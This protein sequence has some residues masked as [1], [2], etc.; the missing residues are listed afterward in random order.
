MELGD[1]ENGLHDL[2]RAIDIS[3]S[4]P[5]GLGQI[6]CSGNLSHYLYLINGPETGLV[7]RHD[8]DLRRALLRKAPD[9]MRWRR[10]IP[11]GT[12]CRLGDGFNSKTRWP[13]HVWNRQW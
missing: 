4:R 7:G 10:S 6:R 11:S 3:E 5:N 1:L 13:K 2:K 8:S 9:S 12:H